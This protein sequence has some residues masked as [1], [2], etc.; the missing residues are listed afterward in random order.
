MSSSHPRS[1]KVRIIHHLR[2][3]R[4]ISITFKGDSYFYHDCVPLNFFFYCF[5]DVRVDGRRPDTSRKVVI[6]FGATSGEVEVS[7]RLGLML[8]LT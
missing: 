7:V 1:S 4:K 3:L 8:N 6:S 5:V 2:H